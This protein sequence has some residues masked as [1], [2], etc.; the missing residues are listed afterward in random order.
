MD[1]IPVETGD[2]EYL[3]PRQIRLS[4]TARRIIGI[5]TTPVIRV[6]IETEIRLS[7]RI[8]IDET[9][10]AHITARFPGRIERLYAD[11]TGIEIEKGQILAEIY[12]PE[13][14]A[15][16]EELLQARLAVASAKDDRSI[17]Q[18]TAS[19]TFNAARDKLHLLGLSNEQIENIINSDTVSEY[20]PILSPISGTVID[21]HVSNGMYIKTGMNLYTIADLSQLWVL[22]DAYE[23]DL[24]WLLEGQSVHFTIPS[25][26]GEAFEATVE[27]INPT[28]DRKNRTF[29]VRAS[30]DNKQNLLK[31]EMLVS[32]V[33]KAHIGSKDNNTNPL[34]IP[35]EAALLTGKR[36][37]VYIK[38]EHGGEPIFEGREIVLGNK[39]GGYYTVESGL[40]EGEIVVTNGAF[41]IDAELQI[42]AKP[43]MMTPDREDEEHTGHNHDSEKVIE[44]ERK[45]AYPT[46]I[47]KVSNDALDALTPIYNVYFELQM[48]LADDSHEKAIS[49]YKALINQLNNIDR[50]LFYNGNHNFIND[51]SGKLLQAAANGANSENIDSSRIAFDLLSEAIIELHNSFGH[52]DTSD[53]YLT[54]CPMAFGNSGAYWL[55]NI[56]TVYNSFYG[57]MMLHCGEIKKKL[58]SERN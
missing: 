46:D 21:K 41:K 45:S 39:V 48:A 14:L 3:D 49:G 1:L 42:R 8:E 50:S 7:G 19:T 53:Y 29:G 17:L 12:S 54:Y 22:L 56:D 16:Q 43:S 23:S 58:V 44:S 27:F 10:L 20:I 5:E 37:V 18:S 36:A 57:E 35:K 55:Q 34:L 47:F 33:L 30:V 28:I 38:K 26:P 51:I 24:P 6:G 2:D 13:L 4:E 11:Y 52:S 15:A 40:K 31:P 9:R 32:G 25:I